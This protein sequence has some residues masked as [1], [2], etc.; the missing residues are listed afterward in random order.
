MKPGSWGAA[1][2]ASENARRRHR[3]GAGG[4]GYGCDSKFLKQ[5]LLD[6]AMV[7]AVAVRYGLF[8]DHMWLEDYS[9]C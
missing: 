2:E 9:F 6:M 5:W 7:V 1:W 8:T 4:Y 3:G